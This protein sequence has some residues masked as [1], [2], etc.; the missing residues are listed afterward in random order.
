[1]DDLIA[2]AVQAAMLDISFDL[3]GDAL[4]RDHRRALAMAL[5]RA[6]PWLADTPHAGV[7]RLNLP[8]GSG[9]LTPLSRRT[10]LTLRVPREQAPA[11]EVLD[12]ATL[13]VGG[14]VLRVSRPRRR[15]LLPFGTLYSHLVASEAADEITFMQEVA[16]SLAALEVTC[17]VICGRHHQ[18]EGGVLL[19]YSLMLDHLSPTDALRVQERGLGRHRQ[20]GC[21]VFVPHKSAAAVGMP[22]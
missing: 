15:E 21:G 8:A 10:R 9:V 6:L 1:M 13:D 22:S 3:E 2:D 20:L 12:G 17:R 14:Q 16:G 4:A 19:G 7:H 11:A 18:V 5:A